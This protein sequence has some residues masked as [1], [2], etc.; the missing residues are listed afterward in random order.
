MYKKTVLWLCPALL[1]FGLVVWGLW[2]TAY[3]YITTRPTALLTEI[4]SLNETGTLNDRSPTHIRTNGIRVHRSI[5]SHRSIIL[6]KAYMRT[7][8][9]LTGSCL[10]ESERSFNVFEP[11]HNIAQVFTDAEKNTFD[12]VIRIR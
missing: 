6:I 5:L 8:S 12:S 9:T 1:T 4:N 2:Y 10:R 3:P 11:L 7:G